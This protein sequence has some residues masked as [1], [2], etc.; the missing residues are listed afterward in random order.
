[1]HRVLVIAALALAPS[2]KSE[3]TEVTVTTTETKPEP[4]AKKTNREVLEKSL[5]KHLAKYAFE[6]FTCPE[7][8]NSA[9]T[10][11]CTASAPNGASLPI[12]FTSTAKDADGAWKSWTSDSNQRV[13]TA[14]E[15]ADKIRETV[16]AE[17]KKAHPKATS[18]LACGTSPVVFVKNKAK[19]MLAIKNPDKQVEIE[20]DDSKGVFDW[21][22]DAF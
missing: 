16:T 12:V 21:S 19:C 13:I 20:I 14:E 10:A 4:A 8:P 11:S 1:M 22:G 7:V 5:R 9:T 18:E 17:V 2:C 6:T 15:L 3:T